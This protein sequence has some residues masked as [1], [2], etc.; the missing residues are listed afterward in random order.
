MPDEKYQ[1]RLG[2]LELLRYGNSLVRQ[3]M[4]EKDIGRHMRCS[5]TNPKRNICR[6]GNTLE[7]DTSA[8]SGDIHVKQAQGIL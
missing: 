2:K 3:T 1:S 5:V 6:F 4:I 7:N 8:R